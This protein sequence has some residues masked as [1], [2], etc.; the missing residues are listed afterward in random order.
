MSNIVQHIHAIDSKI[1][2]LKK[3]Q[4]D[5]GYLAA[6]ITIDLTVGAANDNTEYAIV[7]ME[8]GMVSYPSEILALLI[9]ALEKSREF[10][11]ATARK[12]HEALGQLL[13]GEST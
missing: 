4:R 3:I 9:K 2:R 6:G 7:G 11:M 12:E 10:N 13:K 8:F 1:Q 5:G